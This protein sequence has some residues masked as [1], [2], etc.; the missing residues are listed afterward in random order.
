MK[1]ISKKIRDDVKKKINSNIEKFLFCN[2]EE[3]IEDIN[4]MYDILKELEKLV[5]EFSNQFAIRKKEKNIIDFNDIEHFAL[6]IL[7]KKDE[8]TGKFIKTEIAKNYEEK[9]EEI[10]ID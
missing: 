10:A 7:I 8:K 1:D 2:T 4:N 3:A 9:F 5:N 6:R